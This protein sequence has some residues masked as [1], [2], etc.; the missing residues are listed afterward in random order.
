M[1]CVALAHMCS[2]WYNRSA[3]HLGPGWPNIVAQAGKAVKKKAGDLH[4]LHNSITF[5]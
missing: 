3:V 1:L 4:N 5:S 2:M